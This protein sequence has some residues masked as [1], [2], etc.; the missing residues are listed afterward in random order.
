MYLIFL[1]LFNDALLELISILFLVDDI[2]PTNYCFQSYQWSNPRLSFWS[3]LESDWIMLHKV[4]HQWKENVWRSNFLFR[5]LLNLREQYILYVRYVKKET[6]IIDVNLFRNAFIC[7]NFL[8][9]VRPYIST[10]SRLFMSHT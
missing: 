6:N 2:L 3:M 8:P 4:L 1:H 5:R 7:K 9:I 10:M